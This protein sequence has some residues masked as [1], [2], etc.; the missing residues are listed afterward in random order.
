MRRRT[1]LKAGSV[2]ALLSRVQP[3]NLAA[4]VLSDAAG[5]ARLSPETNLDWTHFVRIGAYGLKSDNADQIVR[6]AEASGV[7][8][9][10]VDNDIPGRYES[11]VNPEPKLKAIRAVAEKAHAV[12]NHAFVYIA[13]T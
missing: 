13:G 5:A 2:A 8:G 1:F 6:D 3:M 9:I 11:F 12:G 4:G 7:F 10:E